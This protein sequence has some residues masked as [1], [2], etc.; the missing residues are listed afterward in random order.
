M[1]EIEIGIEEIYDGSASVRVC[2]QGEAIVEGCVF[3]VD[4]NVEIVLNRP[5]NDI[6]ALEMDVPA[7]YL[8]PIHHYTILLGVNGEM[9]SLGVNLEVSHCNF[10]DLEEA[11]EQSDFLRDQRG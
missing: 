6:Q 2:F 8:G 11:E 5:D 1:G 7:L 4:V 9:R 10:S 3:K